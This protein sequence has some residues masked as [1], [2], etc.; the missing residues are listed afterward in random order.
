MNLD[1][2]LFVS[3]LPSDART[4]R[5]RLWRGL[6]TLG[7]AILRDGVYLLPAEDQRRQ[8]LQDYA[9]AVQTAGGN[10][11]ILTCKTLSDAEAD[12]LCGLFDR[13]D[14]YADWHR[15]VGAAR[16][17]LA[18]LSEAQAR[19]EETTVRRALHEITRTDFFP[20]DIQES[21]LAEMK[22]FSAEI[23]SRFAPDEP[24]PINVPIERR[25]LQRYRNRQWATRS[26]LWIDRVASAWLIRRFIDARA[27]F[28]WLASPA[29][30]P[31]DAVGFDFDGAEF[32]HVEDRVTFEVLITAFGL[33]GDLALTRLGRLI[34][35][36][37][38]G[39]NPV[40]EAPGLLALLSAG[41]ERCAT[42]DA[43]VAA[44][45]SLLNDLLAAFAT[46]EGND[47]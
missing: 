29:D 8:A 31:P 27:Q 16:A 42:D 25:E 43:F 24:S 41:R 33:E 5:M 23:N 7:A 37:D 22:G 21:A 20:T 38:V 9:R 40:P 39:G 18:A 47:R 35:Y 45:S 13:S 44:A 3:H 30:C 32:S 12:E 10:A 11:R 19:R 14:D 6:R 1:W 28:I 17:R 2:D 4:P 15:S 36:L 46:E 34:R 26:D